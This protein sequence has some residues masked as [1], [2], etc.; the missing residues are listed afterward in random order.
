[1][2]ATAAES[3]ELRPPEPAL[4]DGLVTLRPWTD[5]DV[6]GLA[7]LLDGD[8]EITRWL[9]MIPQPYGEADAR[10]YITSTRTSWEEKSSAPF[11]VVLDEPIGSLGLNRIDWNDRAG[12]IGYWIA[13]ET[14]GRGLATRALRLVAG[15]ALGELR[16]ERVYLRAE[17]QNVASCRVA[18]KAGFTREGMLRSAHWNARLGRRVDWVIYSLLP[19]EL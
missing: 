2:A 7:R 4:T 15:W 16:L 10:A 11:A 19:G 8:E 14:R 1:M 3:T 9:D 17:E 18:E 6:P 13:R 5:A 12:E